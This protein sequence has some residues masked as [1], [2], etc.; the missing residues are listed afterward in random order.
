MRLSCQVEVFDDLFIQIPRTYY[1]NNRFKGTLIHKKALTHDIMELRI[2][3]KYPPSISFAPGQYMQLESASYKGRESVIRAYSISSL[4]TD[5][6]HV[7]FMIRKVPDGICST[8][9]FD[10]LE[11]GQE[12]NLGGPY[13]EFRLSDTEAP[14]LFI[15][16]GSGMAPIWSMLR[17]MKEKGIKRKAHYFFGAQSR[18][19]LFYMDELAKLEK[20]LP[21]FRFIPALSNEP[22]ESGWK[23]ERGLITEVVSR[24]FPD[25][26]K[27]E[28][29]LC[30]SP[31]M[32]DACVKVLKAGGMP[33]EQIYYDKF[34]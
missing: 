19:D 23:G 28:A 12:V 30:G 32:I 9:V 11:E 3:L 18:R 27:H 8:W 24:H 22:Q 26:S 21:G 16:G 6:N 2:R 33:E 14:I 13:G 31:P 17:H 7:E 4:P 5:K 20:E 1:S 15:A 25:T 29:Y 34:A 10:H